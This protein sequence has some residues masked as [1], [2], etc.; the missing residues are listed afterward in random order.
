MYADFRSAATCRRFQSADMS[1]HSKGMRNSLAAAGRLFR[2]LAAA[3][4][5]LLAAVRAPGLSTCVRA[6]KPSSTKTG[7]FMHH[8]RLMM[9][10]NHIAIWI[11]VR[12][13]AAPL[14]PSSGQATPNRRGARSPVLRRYHIMIT[15]VVDSCVQTASERIRRGCLDSPILRH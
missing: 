3:Y 7:E 14:R 4:R 9:R 15:D 6:W 8:K 1:A 10:Q 11:K 2:E 13:G 12:F 5:R